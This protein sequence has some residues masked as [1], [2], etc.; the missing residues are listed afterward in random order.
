MSKFEGKK[1]WC[2]KPADVMI[3]NR[4]P[5]AEVV[6]YVCR[7]HRDETFNAIKWKLVAE[8]LWIPGKLTWED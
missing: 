7:E 5:A 2:G 1:C 6:T 8:G 4:L 3:I